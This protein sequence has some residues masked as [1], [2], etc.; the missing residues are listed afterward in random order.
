MSV[1]LEMAPRPER[2]EECHAFH[3]AGHL[4]GGDW[5]GSIFLWAYGS[6]AR[7]VG[8]DKS[9]G[10][11]EFLSNQGVITGVVFGNQGQTCRTAE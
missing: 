5:A 2:G 6:V 3:F 11:F 4:L 9:T 8:L 1:T 7:I 10:Y